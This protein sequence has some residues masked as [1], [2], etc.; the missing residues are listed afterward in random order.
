MID[1][2]TARGEDGREYGP[3]P[4]EVLRR[5]VAEGRVVDDSRVRREGGVFEPAASFPELA[6]LFPRDAA[7]PPPAAA[8]PVVG[9]A[10]L[11]AEF[12]VGGFFREAWRLLSV[13]D[14]ALLGVTTFLLALVPLVPILGKL[15][16]VIAGGALSVGVCRSVL[17]RID[18]RPIAMGDVLRGFDRLPDALAASVLMA[19]LVLVGLAFLVVPGV[20]LAV[21]WLFTFPILAESPAGFWEAMSE[22][23]RLSRGYRWELFLLMAASAGVVF[24]GALAL[25]IGAFAVLPVVLTALGL[26]Y[27]FLRARDGRALRA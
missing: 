8:P 27:R 10:R 16:V 22:S 7:P 1:A 2:W 20:I 23:A 18:G 17:L 14:I 26:A 19:V 25:G 24:L 9:G 5:W 4:F 6:L 11:P 21:L 13:E 15:V 12:S 3:V